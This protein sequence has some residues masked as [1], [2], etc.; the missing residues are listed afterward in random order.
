MN[1]TMALT[2]LV[3]LGVSLCKGGNWLPY[4]GM[5]YVVFPVF[6]NIMVPNWKAVRGLLN[7]FRMITSLLMQPT[8]QGYFLAYAVARTYD[9]RWGNRAGVGEESKEGKNGTRGLVVIQNTLN[10]FVL[11]MLVFDRTRPESQYLGG[12]TVVEFIL[13][14]VLF[15]PS[16]FI[17]LC[18]FIQAFGWRAIT[19]WVSLSIVHHWWPVVHVAKADW[20]I[21]WHLWILLS[22][23]V[24]L[25]GKIVVMKAYEQYRKCKRSFRGQAETQRSLL[26]GTV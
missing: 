24:S 21:P 10:L 22:L 6:L 2:I 1:A 17:A 15:T 19:A 3:A 12:L 14:A 16:L 5:A 26:E 7:P 4:I 18:S 25:L 20:D 9:L 13:A 11:T 8:F 23:V